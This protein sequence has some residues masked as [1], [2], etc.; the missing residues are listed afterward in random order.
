VGCEKLA[1]RAALSI[2]FILGLEN[3]I[4]F[5]IFIIEGKKRRGQNP[6][7]KC[8]ALTPDALLKG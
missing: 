1:A 8:L 5:L 7:S 6:L 3:I 2:P 4:T